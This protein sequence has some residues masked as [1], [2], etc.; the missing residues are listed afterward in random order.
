MPPTNT[1][2]AIVK[3]QLAE[4]DLIE[5]WRYSYLKWGEAQADHYLD[6]LETGIS[7]LATQPCLGTDCSEIRKSYRCLTIQQH[8]VFYTTAKDHIRIIRV[9]HKKQYVV[10]NL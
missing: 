7:R 6:M 9:L 1:A 8:L 2:L 10:L 3:Q 5:I 4:S